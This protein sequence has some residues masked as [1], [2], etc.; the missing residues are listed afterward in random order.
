MS[1]TPD[2]ERLFSARTHHR[3]IQIGPKDA[4]T[5]SR[6][7]GRAPQVLAADPPKCPSCGG[8]LQYLLTLA[9]DTLG[10]GVARGQAVSMLMCLDYDCRQNSHELAPGSSLVFRV[11]EDSP[12]ADAPTPLDGKTEGRALTAGVATPD[13]LRDGAAYIDASKIG[14]R[15]GYVQS[16]GGEEADKARA[17]GADFLFQWSDAGYPPD[18]KVGKSLLAF[19]VA[20][21][22]A[23]LEPQLGE[24]VGFWQNS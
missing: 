22:F 16:W 3:P 9:G 11:H 4:Q 5:G 15:P 2:H 24:V 14:G 7:G 8:P 21:A 13:P 1:A 20:Y 19:G 18:M 10:E 12:R 6:I 23:R 17:G